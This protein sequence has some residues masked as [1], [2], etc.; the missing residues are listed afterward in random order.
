MTAATSIGSSRLNALSGVPT[1]GDITLS[2]AVTG[3]FALTKVGSNTLFVT[4]SGNTYNGIVINGGRVVVSG[5]GQL[6]TGAN[7]V[8]NGYGQPTGIIPSTTLQLDN[9]ATASNSRL[10]SRALSMRNSHLIIDGHAT[11]AVNE[12][13][14]ANALD[15]ALGHSV[16]TLNHNGANVTLTA[17]SLTRNGSATL[18]I[19]GSDDNIGVDGSTGIF[20][21]TAPIPVGTENTAAQFNDTDTS[22]ILPWILIDNGIATPGLGPQTLSFARYDTILGLTNLVTYA[23][24]LPTTGTAN[25]TGDV[26]LAI[27]FDLP[28]ENPLGAD[29]NLQTT[30]VN[31]ITFTDQP[32]DL[33]VTLD[34]LQILTLDSGGIL[35]LSSGTFTGNG[36]LNVAGNRQF[37]I[38]TIGAST[39]LNANVELG[40]RLAPT[41][42]GLVKT[43][44]GTLIL[45]ERNNYT[46]STVVNLGTLKLDG[47]DNTILYSFTTGTAFN[48]VNGTPQAQILAVAPGGIVDLNGT[49]QTFNL[50]QGN[51]GQNVAGAGGIITNTNAA[52]SD[53]RL[54]VNGNVNWQGSINGNTNLIKSGGSTTIFYDNNA[55]SGT[56]L[57]QGGVFSLQDQGRLSGTSGITVSRAVLRW[58]DTG[59]QQ[60]TNRLGATTPITLNGAALNYLSRGGTDG[61]MDIGSIHLAGGASYISATPNAGTATVKMGALTRTVNSTITFAAGTGTPG[62]N[63]FF[64]F[65]SAPTLT[66]GMIGGWAYAIGVDAVSV[67]TNI[68]FATYDT[69]TGVRML[70]ATQL[71]S[72]FND[73]TANV[74]FGASATVKTGG[75]VI[76]S[77]TLNNAAI[78]LSFAAA[79][80]VLNITSGGLL[81]GLDN[82][83][84]TI[85][86]I[87]LPG[88]LTAGGVNP[89]SDV[90]LYVT[91]ASNNMQ[92]N[93]II[94]D[95]PTNG[96]KLHLVLGSAGRNDNT[97][98]VTLAN[99]NTY[100]GTTYINGVRVDLANTTGSGNAITGDLIIAGGIEN[101]GD[102]S[103]PDAVRVLNR[104]H[105]QIA[106]TANVTMLG[107]SSWELFGFNETINNL[108]FQND[109]GSRN[110]SGP[111]VQTGTGVLTLNG[112]VTATNLVNASAISL[113]AGNINFGVDN[114]LS[115]TVDKVAGASNGTNQQIGLA[116]NVNVVGGGTLTKLGAGML[117]LG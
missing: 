87:A 81:G 64:Y 88:I 67:A 13:L 19:R 79:N 91:N 3:A 103:N 21:T 4:G 102:S 83:G 34:D 35:A 84:K 112:N 115:V 1:A 44:E 27:V 57:I 14:G 105:N 68:E 20:F 41:T 109:G 99:A 33:T 63:P 66:N 96:A 78:T 77:L 82:N 61:V 98:R 100:T 53:L 95:N 110:N 108:N 51:G 59:M 26:N 73:P 45:G 40:G 32:S 15:I 97:A 49:D 80:D 8:M 104:A 90:Y 58:D 42:G 94:A 36:S 2:G 65:D 89:A 25:G 92:I 48:A 75:A 111:R 24:D 46:G 76:N 86:S 101:T 7:H 5:A 71:V 74:R 43:G 17:G 9:T 10:G 69:A 56:T 116:M 23:T 106:D 113:I 28:L 117:S 47:G 70:S 72:H 52:A 16:I 37:V 60:M 22:G 12:N 11:T 30:G 55:Y 39:V 29:Q 62:A 85:G 38:H 114:A 6:G 54:V 93:S 31:S 107:G 50:I 18:V